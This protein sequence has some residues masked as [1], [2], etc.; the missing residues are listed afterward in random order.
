ME[1]PGAT[2]V[3]TYGTVLIDK[4]TKDMVDILEKDL[5]HIESLEE[6]ILETIKNR[7]S[8]SDTNEYSD[9]LQSLLIEK[10]LKQQ[11]YM[12]HALLIIQRK[13]VSC[14]KRA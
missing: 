6:K 10:R 3:K 14:D 13:E 8:F 5:D 2:S 9:C 7:C 12:N 1:S 11:E 4:N